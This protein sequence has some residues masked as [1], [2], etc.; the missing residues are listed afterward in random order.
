MTP[1]SPYQGRK[2]NKHYMYTK[3]F[4]VQIEVYVKDRAGRTVRVLRGAR[5]NLRDFLDY[6]RRN[7]PGCRTNVVR[8]KNPYEYAMTKSGQWVRVI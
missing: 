4:A 8:L 3:T 2:E 1:L 6:A 7:H 5:Y